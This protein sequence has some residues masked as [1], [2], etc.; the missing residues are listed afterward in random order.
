[1][2]NNLSPKATEADPKETLATIA[3]GVGDSLSES[4]RMALQ[5]VN[6][7]LVFWE[8][9][10][11]RIC[12]INTTQETFRCR[13]HYYL[14]WLATKEEYRDYQNAI[15]ETQRLNQ[16]KHWYPRWI[17]RVEFTNA[18]EVLQF[19]EHQ[20]EKKGVK[21]QTLK[22]FEYPKYEI[23]NATNNSQLRSS[24]KP[25]DERFIQLLGFDPNHGQWVKCRYEADVIFAEEMEL[26]N[27]PFD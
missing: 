24:W 25:G 20:G 5:E 4:R 27:F 19:E 7:R 22:F 23:R 12:D 8:C 11:K 6:L 14:T 16:P 17:P 18:V 1:K 9:K 26:E 3:A 13:F 2:L 15:R 10:I 21:V